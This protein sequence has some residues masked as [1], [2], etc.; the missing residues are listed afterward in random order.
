MRA[1]TKREGTHREG[2][3]SAANSLRR[4]VKR[5][6]GELNDALRV[7]NGEA[8]HAHE[9]I[10]EDERVVEHGGHECRA[11]LEVIA[12]E[13]SMQAEVHCWVRYLV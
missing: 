5:R 9:A 2:S 11:C 4:E 7:L 1:R 13:G 6:E 8:R 10:A 12:V 3:E